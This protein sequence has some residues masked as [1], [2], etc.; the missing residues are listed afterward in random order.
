[1]S[2]NS[3]FSQTRTTNASGVFSLAA[4]ALGLPS[5]DSPL[6]LGS[7]T[8]H[9]AAPPPASLPLLPPAGLTLLAALRDGLGLRF[10]RGRRSA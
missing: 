9:S 4:P 2:D 10:A 5:G 1:M 6:D 7:V 8:L 3:G